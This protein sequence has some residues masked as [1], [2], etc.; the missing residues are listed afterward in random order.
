MSLICG[1]NPM[2]GTQTPNQMDP[3]LAYDVKLL[4]PVKSDDPGF[5]GVLTDPPK[6]LLPFSFTYKYPDKHSEKGE[7]GKVW[8]KDPN[9]EASFATG[10]PDPLYPNELYLICP[11]F[12]NFTG[13]G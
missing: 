2:V 3:L 12:K 5:T 9:L 7:D 11:P 10:Q 1:R 4:R 13:F 6:E 8:R